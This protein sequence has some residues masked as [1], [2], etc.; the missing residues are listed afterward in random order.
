MYFVFVDVYCDQFFVGQQCVCEFQV[1]IYY[2]QLVGV[3][4]VVCFG[5][6]VVFYVGFG[7]VCYCQVV[8]DVVVEVVWIDEIVVGVVWWIDVDEFY[9]VGV[10][11]V[12]Q[13][14]YVEVV[15]FDYQMVCVVLCDV[16]VGVGLQCVC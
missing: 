14:Y 1:W 9:F 5:V 11:F 7:L 8:V 3:E 13:F 15:V 2:V 4:L 6:G 10:V 12:Q 16:V